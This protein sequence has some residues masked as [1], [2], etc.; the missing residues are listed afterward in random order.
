MVLVAHLSTLLQLAREKARG[1]EAGSKGVSGADVASLDGHGEEGS[2]L[3]HLPCKP[4]KAS[5]K[6]CA[7]RRVGRE[8]GTSLPGCGARAKPRRISLDETVIWLLKFEGPFIVLELVS[9]LEEPAG[10][11][12]LSSLCSRAGGQGCNAMGWIP[13]IGQQRVPMIFHSTI[14]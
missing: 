14:R 5:L 12:G 13:A 9:F 7:C 10:A 6:K 4:R 3:P 8:A 2:Q 1:S 11:G